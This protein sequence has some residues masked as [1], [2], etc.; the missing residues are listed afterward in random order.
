MMFSQDGLNWSII[1]SLQSDPMAVVYVKKRDGSLEELG[2]TEVIM[3]CLDP[4]WIEKINVAYQFEIVQQ[5][6]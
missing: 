6:V 2:R 3:N 4:T 1:F 5:L